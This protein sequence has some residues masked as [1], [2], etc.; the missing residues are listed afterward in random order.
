MAKASPKKLIVGVLE[1]V[2]ITISFNQIFH[3]K[4][5]NRYGK[6]S[7]YQSKINY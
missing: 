7:N 4:K 6:K 2:N 1:L 3:G 5:E